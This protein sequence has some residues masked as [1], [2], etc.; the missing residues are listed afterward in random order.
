MQKH[1]ERYVYWESYWQWSVLGT[2]WEMF[3]LGRILANGE[4]VETPVGCHRK[5]L[6]S[7]CIGRY[8]YWQSY[9]QR[10]VL[11]S[12]WE[13]FILVHTG[14]RRVC[15]NPSIVY[16]QRRLGEN[17]S[18]VYWERAIPCKCIGKDM[19]TGKATGNGAYW[20]R[21]GKSSYWEEYWQMESWWKLQ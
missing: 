5:G 19:Y 6:Y 12:C 7:E 9:W 2:C 17:P 1:R 4:L 13:M 3:I 10:N 15:E 16:W 18:I 8:V 20:E 14:K 21:V 11:G